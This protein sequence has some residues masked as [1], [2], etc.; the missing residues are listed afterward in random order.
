MCK[1]ELILSHTSFYFHF[2]CK[3]FP[4]IFANTIIVQGVFGVAKIPAKLV[5]ICQIMEMPHRQGLLI[6]TDQ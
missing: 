5:I 2:F 6:Q 4:N 1:L 3:H